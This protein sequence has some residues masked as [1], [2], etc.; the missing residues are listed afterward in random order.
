LLFK[1]L[2]QNDSPYEINTTNVRNTMLCES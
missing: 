1:T 2:T